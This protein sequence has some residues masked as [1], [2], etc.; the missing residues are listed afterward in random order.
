MSQE[1]VESVR[2]GV[3]S[4]E[5]FWAMLDEHAVWDLRNHQIPDL[6]GVYIGRDA[7]IEASRHWWGTW[8]DYRI[9]A[10]ELVD[11]GS[12]VVVVVHQRGRGKGSGAPFEQRFAQV[13]AFAQGRII[14]WELY[15]DKAAALEAA[16]LSE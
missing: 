12:S 4:V 5:A 14:R 16:G 3:Q 13:W 15:P 7:V 6:E 9:D 11:A 1:N 8:T 2:R 10:E